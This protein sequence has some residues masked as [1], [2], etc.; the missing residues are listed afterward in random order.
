MSGALAAAMPVYCEPSVLPQLRHKTQTLVTTELSKPEIAFAEA[1]FR[2]RPAR[3]GV[4]AGK[5]QR[6]PLASLLGLASCSDSSPLN[7]LISQV[8]QV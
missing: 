8:R 7:E 5:L 1:H 4:Q 3:V 6:Q 2:L